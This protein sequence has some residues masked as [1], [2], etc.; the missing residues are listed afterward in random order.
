MF[1][2]FKINTKIIVLVTSIVLIGVASDS[3]ISYYRAKKVVHNSYFAKL[4]MLSNNYQHQIDIYFEDIQEKLEYLSSDPAFEEL[5]TNVYNAPNSTE[6][7]SLR[8]I[9]KH[10]YIDRFLDINDFEEIILLNNHSQIIF[11]S[12]DL[13]QDG[14][15]T[16][17][18]LDNLTVDIRRG[19]YYI[20]SPVR[21][22]VHFYNYV[23]L[24]I[25]LDGKGEQGQII[26]KFETKDIFSILKIDS[27]DFNYDFIA[28]KN[29]HEEIYQLNHASYS[30][31]PNVEEK[32]PM[33]LTLN[34]PAITTK[35]GYYEEHTDGV[36]NEYLSIW[37]FYKKLGIG[38]QI[39]A[40][41]MNAEKELWQF[42]LYTIIIGIVI[43]VIALILT[44]MFSQVITYP[45]H[46][47]RKILR[48]VSKGVLPNNITTKLE[49]EL[50]DMIMLINDIIAYLKRSAAF[51]NNIGKQEFES[52]YKPISDKDILGKALIQMQDNLQSVDRKDNLRN[53]VVTGVA[54]ISEI[55]RNHD[56][57]ETL[58][59]EVIRYLCQRTQSQQ[60]A[61]YIVENGTD[62]NSQI[63]L[64]SGYAF[65]K[66]KHLK[67][68]I[69]PGTGLVGQALL[70]QDFI[71]R[72][73]IPEDYFNIS[74]GLLGEQKPNSIIVAPL[75]TNNVVYGL[76]ELASIN[77]LND[78]SCEFLKEISGIVSQTI[79]NI[80]VSQH[81]RELLD[82]SQRM[83]EELQEQQN[84]L[85]E[86][87]DEMHKAQI[88]LT[89]SNQELENKIAEVNL[90]Q[91]KTNFLLEN[92]SELI[93]IFDKQGNI[94]YVSP[95]VHRIT[96]Y[97]E[98]DL[99]GTN[100]FHLIE[101]T[102]SQK[103]QKLYQDLLMN[104]IS[105][106]TIKMQYYK[107]DGSK[108]WL[109]ATGSNMLHVPSIQGIVFNYQ[110]ITEQI[111]AEEEERKRG[112]MQALSENSLD[113]ILR[114]GIKANKVYYINPAIEKYTG[115][116]P[117]QLINK[118]LEKTN[119]NTIVITDLLKIVQRVV[120]QNEK[121]KVELTFP[122][123]HEH[124]IMEVDAIP[125][126]NES[127]ETDFVL[128]VMHDITEKKKNESVLRHTNNQIK[129][130]INYAENIQ[131]A[132]IPDSTELQ[133]QF[134][135]SFVYF[136]PRDIVSGDFPWMYTYGDTTYVAA[137]DCTG[138]GVPGAMISFVGFFLLQNIIENDPTLT[139]GQVLDRLDDALAQT[140]K[141]AKGNA[142]IKDGM[143]VALCKIDK[144]SH[145]IEFAGAQRPMYLIK[146]N[147]ILYEF[148]GSKFPIGGGNSYQ[149]TGFTNNKTTYEIG[150]AVYIF[151][152]GLPDQFGGDGNQKYGTRKVRDMIEKKGNGDLFEFEKYL[153]EDL[154][155]WQ[156][157]TEQT[158]DIL[159][160]GIKF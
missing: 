96:G 9:L 51:A 48:L 112:Q 39:K 30:R 145:A 120:K 13:T 7:D 94:S 26:C 35:R 50:G 57:I 147:G 88:S 158:D 5:Y 118:T 46:K 77:T 2:K 130:S 107:K 154:T 85:Q 79:F 137:V 29:Y 148:K 74:S 115:I 133:Q 113:I 121:I 100:D 105:T 68:I 141:K 65:G 62:G 132:I 153:H 128:L 59:D 33:F 95:S 80:N 123:D 56:N 22:G 8:K 146:K 55:L 156:G 139:A 1:N 119:L 76:V 136:R 90:E 67:E 102:S 144:S 32:S 91:A 69:E 10:T 106:A 38:I 93:M 83:S 19:D 15:H 25:D 104:K 24:P 111:R 117:G 28:Y 31:I 81:T 84:R 41:Y 138:H 40:E 75:M 20:N 116:K 66:K 45:V 149:K 43:I 140:F 14:T 150:D 52:D 92:A 86:S 4:Q 87:A 110:D 58:S 64:I 12:N 98:D 124:K 152:D 47:L 61:F 23:C 99:L 143:D 135:E 34:N 78:H 134:N 54:E 3:I 37:T 71:I 70:E 27:V 125:E 122:S 109:K 42:N 97:R 89:D 17:R 157:K 82:E 53:W 159:L 101:G 18:T 36:T 142:N 60:G 127:G 131:R 114:L 21:E 103:F 160:I 108:I 73:E 11:K 16:F 129:D 151:S 126:F 44:I 49:D 72:T 155:Q 63:K 6:A